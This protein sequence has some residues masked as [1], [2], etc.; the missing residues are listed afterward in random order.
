MTL[1]IPLVEDEWLNV[2]NEPIS[3][4]P[5]R[6]DPITLSFTK[7]CPAQEDERI[8]AGMGGVGISGFAIGWKENSTELV[9]NGNPQPKY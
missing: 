1:Q 7:E 8:I 2:A 5:P 9:F 4:K 6:E 3:I